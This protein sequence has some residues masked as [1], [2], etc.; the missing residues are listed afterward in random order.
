[1]TLILVL[2]L[3]TFSLNQK[4]TNI[5]LDLELGWGLA[6]VLHRDDGSPHQLHSFTGQKIDFFVS[7]N[8][9]LL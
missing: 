8:L 3:T 9:F 5:D 6:W 4:Q 1:M 2:T 7:Q